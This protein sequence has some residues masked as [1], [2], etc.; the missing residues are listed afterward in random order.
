MSEFEDKLNA[1]LSNPDSMARVMQLA[2]SLSSSENGA[3]NA[4]AP[5]ER[6]APGPPS[7]GESAAPFIDPQLLQRFAPM[8]A[9]V[10]SSASSNA[11]QLLL[12]L[13]PY[14]KPEKQEKVAKAIQIAK[15]IRVGKKFF[16]GLEGQN[17]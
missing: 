5:P 2:Q 8:L 11:S 13:Q 1:L 6:P 4:E 7:D 17:V 15:L 10:Q 12:A 14:L 3:A 9:E 16:S